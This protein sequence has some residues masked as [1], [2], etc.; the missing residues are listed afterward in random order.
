MNLKF[1][2]KCKVNK[3]ITEFHKN[4]ARSNRDGYSSW[5]KLCSNKSRKK[6]Y[7]NNKSS[8]YERQNSWLIYKYGITKEQYDNILEQQDCVC[9]LCGGTNLNGKALSVDHNHKTGEIRGL[10]CSHCNR[11]LGWFEKRKDKILKYLER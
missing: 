10:L 9:Y 1:C 5:C 2:P 11:S 8:K 7:E 3:P 4:S 6:N